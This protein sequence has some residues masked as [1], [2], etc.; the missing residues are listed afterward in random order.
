V[1]SPP[2]GNAAVIAINLFDYVLGRIRAYL[3][4]GVGGRVGGGNQDN[5]FAELLVQE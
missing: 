3:Q 4:A 5:M 2:S 1:A